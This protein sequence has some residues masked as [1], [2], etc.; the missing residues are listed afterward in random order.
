MASN[1]INITLGDMNLIQVDML[2]EL[3]GISRSEYI[4]MLINKEYATEEFHGN[5]SY[6]ELHRRFDERL[7][8]RYQG[9]IKEP[10]R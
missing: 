9:N 1:R 3:M 6:D 10:S 8:Q 2:A 5:V 4:G 7:K